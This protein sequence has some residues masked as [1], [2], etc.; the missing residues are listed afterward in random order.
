MLLEVRHSRSLIQTKTD[1]KMLDFAV[2]EIPSENENFPTWKES[3]SE[4]HKTVSD[5]EEVYFLPNYDMTSLH[6]QEAKTVSPQWNQP[7]RKLHWSK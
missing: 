3:K 7:T 4:K 5:K 6:R 1:E 2:R